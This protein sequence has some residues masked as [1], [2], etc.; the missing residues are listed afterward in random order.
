MKP[1]QKTEQQPASSPATTANSELSKFVP[2]GE[3]TKA[4][5]PQ[6]PPA[7]VV[8]PV[9]DP[10]KLVSAPPKAPGVTSKPL[11][12]KKP[13]AKNPKAKNPAKL[14][15]P[16]KPSSKPQLE[17]GNGFS[18]RL[19]SGSAHWIFV[20]TLGKLV[21]F[22]EFSKQLETVRSPSKAQ[23]ET[24]LKKMMVP[25][26][27]VIK[28][29]YAS[30]EFQEYK[31]KRQKATRAEQKAK[32]DQDS[33]LSGVLSVAKGSYTAMNRNGNKF[34]QAGIVIRPFPLSP[35]RGQDFSLMMFPSK[36]SSLVRQMIDAGKGVK[37][38]L[39]KNSP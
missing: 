25:K 29:V 13:K 2:Q 21:S 3:A 9:S 15:K 31:K 5:A 22:E 16:K 32:L 18:I 17:L 27:K 23:A 33:M 7:A 26:D 38:E 8:P 1:E 30:K 24:I 35:K 36:F 4:E 10:P 34:R 14:P 6:P 20:K 37:E 19:Q 28:K 12:K 39:P 11:A